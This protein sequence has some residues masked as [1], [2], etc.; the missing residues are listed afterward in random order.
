METESSARRHRMAKL[1]WHANKRT[2]PPPEQVSQE[3][4]KRVDELRDS[5]AFEEALELL[6]A[7]PPAS[8]LGDNRALVRLGLARFGIGD[9]DGALDAFERA[10]RVMDDAKA[11]VAVNRANLL[12]VKG[13]YDA[14]LE[15][16]YQARALAPRWFASHLIIMAVLECREGPSDRTAVKQAVAEMKQ[17]WEEYRTNREFWRYLMTDVDYSSLRLRPEFV[18]LFGDPPEYVR[19]D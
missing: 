9:Y 8:L 5:G 7:Q 19:G 11:R 15:A 16:A 1:Q 4:L 14:A 12:K 2:Q 10:D 17:M 3:I 18:S 13:D 6:H